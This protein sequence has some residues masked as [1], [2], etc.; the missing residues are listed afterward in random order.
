MKRTAPTSTLNRS[1]TSSPSPNVNCEL[2]P[3]GVEHHPRSRC[4]EPGCR[5]Q[6]GEPS[7]LLP[8][9]DLDRRRRSAPA[10]GRRTPRCWSP[11]AGPPYRPRRSPRP[12]AARPHPPSPPRLR[13][14]ARI[15]SGSS[16]PD[17]SR[18]SP[19]R[20]ISA[21]SASVRPAAVRPSLADVELH[22]VGADVD[23]REPLDAEARQRLQ[24]SRVVHVRPHGQPELAHRRD[25]HRGIFGL[26]RDRPR[27]ARPARTSVS[28]ARQS[29]TR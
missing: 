21:R 14:S 29:P 3:A 13:S 20:V 17:R 2:P 8:G 23:D 28:S 18:P 12:A 10:P 11:S 27:R 6:V 16:R 26:D 5:R 1:S 24:P 19:S 15:G 25:H 22:R 4:R 7:L 9:D